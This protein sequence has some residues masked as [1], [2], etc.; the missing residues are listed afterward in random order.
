MGM[1]SSTPRVATLLVPQVFHQLSNYQEC[2]NDQVSIKQRKVDM[3]SLMHP[4][5]VAMV[6]GL[7]PGKD[8]VSDPNQA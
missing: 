3:T 5:D 4:T 8:Q 1:C 7:I 6:N 2:R